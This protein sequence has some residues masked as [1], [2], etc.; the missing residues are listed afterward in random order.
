MEAKS[1][2]TTYF[3][4]YC[5]KELKKTDKKFVVV[6]QTSS[7]TNIENYPPVL[8]YHNYVEAGTLIML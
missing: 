4:E 1:D 6:Y 2:L 5:V 7:V 8:K 3:A